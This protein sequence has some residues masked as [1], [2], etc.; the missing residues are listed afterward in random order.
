MGLIVEPG[1]VEYDIRAVYIA[2]GMMTL[3]LVVAFWG[4]IRQTAR[5]I[6][7]P[8]EPPAPM[9]YEMRPGRKTRK[10]QDQ[11]R[12]RRKRERRSTTRAETEVLPEQDPPLS[13]GTMKSGP[14][15]V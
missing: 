9:E 15:M 1:D 6:F 5:G 12:R 14:D 13:Y 7:M 2:C 8:F 11:R 4:L 3:M 10:Q